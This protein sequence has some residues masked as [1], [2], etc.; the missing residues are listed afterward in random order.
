[1]YFFCMLIY[2]YYFKGNWS[3]T[4]EARAQIHVGLDLVLY[5]ETIS[6]NSIDVT[7]KDENDFVMTI[8]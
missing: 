4:A 2:I 1:M 3:F 5:N 7:F 8:K 6:V